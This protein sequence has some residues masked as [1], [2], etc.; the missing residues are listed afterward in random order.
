MPEDAMDT[1]EELLQG[2]QN[3]V[4]DPETVY[5]VRSAQQLLHVVRQKHDDLNAAIDET[6]ADE[7]IIENLAELGYLE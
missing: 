5:K 7:E 2:V 3:D 4:Q 6:V 1:I